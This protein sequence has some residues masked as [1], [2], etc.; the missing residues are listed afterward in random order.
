MPQLNFVLP[1]WMYWGV[2]LLFPFIAMYLV[3]R[4][5]RLGEP[6]GP[7]LFVAYLFWVCA[8]FSGLHR[9]YLRNAWGFVFIPVFLGILYVNDDIRDRL[10]DVSRTRAAYESAHV[11]ANRIRPNPGVTLSPEATQRVATAQARETDAKG[12]F[13]A[14]AGQLAQRRSIARWLAILMAAMLLIDAVLLPGLV[15]RREVYEAAHPRVGLAAPVPDIPPA[16]THEDPTV[17]LHTRATDVIEW[18]NV[19]IGVFAAYWAL[20]SV[21]AYFYEVIARFVFNSR[22]NWVHE[23][24]FLMYGMQYMLAGAMPTARTST[25]GSTSSMPSSRRAGRRSPISSPRYSSSSSSERCSGRDGAS[26]R[27]PSTTT[28]SRSLSG[29]CST[30]R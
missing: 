20:I 26:H 23:S 6:T 13:D 3:A 10:E 11:Q 7:S 24:M 19:K 5:K 14:A 21:F 8:G 17:A 1:H 18:V 9:F 2:L 12:A 15:R 25:S 16:G 28:R 29:A 22:T 4:Q 27:M 30:G